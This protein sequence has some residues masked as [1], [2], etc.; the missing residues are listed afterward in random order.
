MWAD[1]QNEII[2]L[3]WLHLMHFV[4]MQVKISCGLS[5][6]TFDVVWFKHGVIRNC[7]KTVTCGTL[8]PV[9]HTL[10]FASHLIDLCRYPGTEIDAVC[11]RALLI[12]RL[13]EPWL[14]C[15]AIQGRI[16][17]FG[18]PRQWKHFRPLFQAVFLSGGGVLPSR[19]S[20]TTPPSPKTEIT[21]IL[22]Y[23]LNFASIIEFKM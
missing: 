3:S 9:L 23:I 16:K 2:S 10:M 7:S 5:L 21:N 15:Q 17:L 19:Q 14:L 8:T 1:I 11:R 22:F 18:A 6:K 12:H 4:Q 20:N 13:R